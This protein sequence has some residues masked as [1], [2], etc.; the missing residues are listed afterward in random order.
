MTGELHTIPGAMALDSSYR[1]ACRTGEG[2]RRESV[3]QRLLGCVLNGR[4]RED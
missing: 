4:F 2:H 1:D 3:G